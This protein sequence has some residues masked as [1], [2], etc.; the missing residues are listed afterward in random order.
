MLRVFKTIDGKIY[1]IHQEE[2]LE[3]AES[4]SW[5]ALTRPSMEELQLVA[6]RYGIEMDD[7][8]CALDV[9]ERSRL[10]VEEGYTMV[11]LDIPVSDEKDNKD[12]Y[13]TIPFAVIIT[14]EEIITVCL[15]DTP[16][17]TVFMDGRIRGFDTAKRTKFLY[18]MLYRNAT[19]YL[20]Y[21]RIIHKQSE[22]V[23]KK[24][25][26]VQ[27]NQDLLQMLDLEK[28]LVYITSSL[29]GNEA[30]LEKLT[31]TSAIP[32]TEEEFEL[33]E[34]VIIENKQAIEMAKIYTDI[35]SGSRNAYAS[36]I[37]NNLYGVMKILTLLTIVFAVPTILLAAF[38]MNVGG[39][40]M[41]GSSLGFFVI[42]IVTILLTV[43]AGLLVNKFHKFK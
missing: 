13:H 40:P 34:D 12:F 35:L 43:L 41:A 36:V 26:E 10:L 8:K 29:R 19:M 20:Q 25:N 27:K 16:V 9:E 33:L 37:N 28:G 30:V 17:L 14:A 6:N 1:Q 11:V 3:Q 21:L 18:Q 42:C 32:H 38:G 2:G 22:D 15:E 23:E 39:V 5:I 24:L 7:L 31:R 4:N